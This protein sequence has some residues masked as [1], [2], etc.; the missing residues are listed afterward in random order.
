MNIINSLNKNSLKFKKKN[1]IETKNI[2]VSYE[3]FFEIILKTTTFLK[4]N[5]VTKKSSLAVINESFLDTI[6][7]IFASANI[8]NKIILLDDYYSDEFKTKLIKKLKIDIIISNYLNLK[9]LKDFQNIKSIIL[10]K[11][12]DLITRTE[13][14]KKSKILNKNFIKEFLITFSSGSTADPKPIV[15][16]EYTKIKRAKNMKRL[17]KLTHNDK[18]ILSC[19]PN[20][21]LGFRI[22]FTS[23]LNGMTLSLID[24]FDSRNYMRLVKNKKCSFPILLG[25]QMYELIRKNILSFKFKKGILST[26]SVL[27]NQLKEKIV[28]S[29]NNLF[30]MYGASEIGTVTYFCVNKNKDQINSVGKITGSNIKLKILSKEGKFHKHNQT[31]EII[32]KNNFMFNNYYLDKKK[33]KENFFKNYFKTGDYG[34]FDNKGFLYFKGRIK[35]IIK[36][37]GI[38]IFA[39]DIEKILVQDK[40]IDEIIVTSKK[41]MND[42]L[43]IFYIKKNKNL[44]KQ[45]VQNVCLK[46]LSKFQ[47]PN[48]IIFVKNFEK[49]SIG[50]IDRKKIN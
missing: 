16:S 40:F 24:K 15:F 37:S 45:Y 27:P 9:N 25:S 34:Y 42:N 44:N 30:E 10:L 35:N 50:K 8:G 33:T 28:K 7:L 18:L 1:C 46:K 48:E 22:I 4:K 2:S 41:K 20:H 23:I 6:I 38:N 13:N 21:S 32:C 39:E 14:E 49:T 19:S 47:Y 29:K 26:S 36:R 12:Y 31:G 11:N 5:N 43:L 3:K 17:F